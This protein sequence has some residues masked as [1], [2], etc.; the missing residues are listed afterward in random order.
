MQKP[1]S[2]VIQGGLEAETKVKLAVVD[3]AGR[4][5]VPT[6]NPREGNRPDSPDLIGGSA[7][8]T[9][10]VTGKDDRFDL[11]KTT[12]REGTTEELLEVAFSDFRLL[13]FQVDDK[14][15][16]G[17][18]NIK[19]SVALAAIAQFSPEGIILGRG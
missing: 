1:K 8:I 3:W 10:T 12:H 14:Q 15:E 6:R 7:D 18:V 9:D 2:E 5:L 13:G 16:A 19:T 17:T 11:L 4:V